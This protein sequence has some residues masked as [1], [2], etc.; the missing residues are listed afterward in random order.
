MRIQYNIIDQRKKLSK[1]NVVKRLAESL[2][3][4]L[5]KAGQKGKGEYCL[6]NRSEVS[7][8]RTKSLDVLI[9]HLSRK[10]EK[11]DKYVMNHLKKEIA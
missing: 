11:R 4:E 1:F 8:Y 3:F 6:Y 2:G 10:L 9:D 5:G 7:F